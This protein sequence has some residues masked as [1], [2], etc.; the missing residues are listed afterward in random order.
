MKVISQNPEAFQRVI[1]EEGTG[2]NVPPP[3]PPPGSIQITPEEA[4]AIERV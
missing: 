2:P 4:A 3:P 1:M